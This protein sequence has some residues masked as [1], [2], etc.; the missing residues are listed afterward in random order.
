LR[1]AGTSGA[2]E[3][4]DHACPLRP[5]SEPIPCPMSDSTLDRRLEAY[6]ASHPPRRATTQAG[7]FEYTVGGAGTRTVVILHGGGSIAE[8]AHPFSLALEP[9]LR[10]IAVDWPE[11]V[12]TVDDVVGGVMAI[13]DVEGIA[14]FSVLG[15]SMGGMLGQCLTRAYPDRVEK[16]AL[17]VSMGPSPR[18][19]RRFRRHR[20]IL[21]VIPDALLRAASKRAVA[22]WVSQGGS[23]AAP[24]DLAFIA[25]HRRWMFDAGKVSK[26]SLLS[27]AGVLIDFF[28]RAF[29]PG[30][31]GA[32][33]VLILEAA[34]DRMVDAAE[35]ERLR[36][37][38][39]GARVV[40][41]GESDHFAGV[42]APDAITAVL[43]D[44]LLGERGAAP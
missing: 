17:Y 15:F 2:L 20:W 18:Y 23:T 11:T 19:A 3:I 10:V 27:D 37:L 12:R 5:S 14:R 7:T 31:L 35:R 43:R 44:F 1:E 40:T 28:S 41:L 26:R 36:R 33:E 9:S 32:C 4:T 30:D 38:Y 13:V 8:S 24:D 39:P 6:R 16:L 34:R 29:H 22:K 42:L 21:G 25:G